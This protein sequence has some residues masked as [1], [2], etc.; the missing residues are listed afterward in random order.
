MVEVRRRVRG[1]AEVEGVAEEGEGVVEGGGGEGGGGRGGWR[2]RGGWR[3]PRAEVGVEE[4]RGVT[5]HG[6]VG[7]RPG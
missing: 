7:L 2:W 6:R 5:W 4:W 3:R 1:W